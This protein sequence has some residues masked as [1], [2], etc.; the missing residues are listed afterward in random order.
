MDFEMGS[1]PAVLL[2]PRCPAQDD[3]GVL[4]LIDLVAEATGAS[5]V[6]L[7]LQ[8]DTGARQSYRRGDT[9]TA[10]QS[11]PLGSDGFT[12]DLRIGADGSWI[13]E[14]EA[15]VVFSLDRIL[16]CRRYREQVSLFRGAL[17]TTSIAVLLFDD[18][19]GIVYANAPA[20]QLLCRQTEDGLSVEVPA[21]RRQPLVTYLLSTVDGLTAA[22]QSRQPWS[23]TLTL[24]DGS[25][26]ACEI[27]HV[28]A[29]GL[30]GSRGVLVFLQPVPALSKLCLESFCARHSLS[31]REEDVVRLLFDGLTTS[32]MAD[33]LAI[34]LHTVRDHLKRLYKKTGARS[35]SELLSRISSAGERPALPD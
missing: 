30:S 26:L 13:P 17:D 4:E 29:G 15:M 32:D 24:S 23:E 1:K 3:P 9:G 21:G 19:G 8:L 14:L 6:Q 18:S 20:D 11:V 2:Q 22:R 34:S 31:P 16:L 5:S 28:D 33:R 35:R 25:V 12:A 27:M 10:G 7:D